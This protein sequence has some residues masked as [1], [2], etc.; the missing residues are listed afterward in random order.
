L[1]IPPLKKIPSAG[2]NKIKIIDVESI[3]YVHSDET[4]VFVV[5]NEK[6]YFTE[7][8]LKVLENRTKL[9]RC[10]KQFLINPDKIDEILFDNN[11]TGKI[12]TISQHLI[13]IS[14]HYLKELK[15]KLGL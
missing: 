13:P 8:T 4:G 10:H 7:I 1:E 11:S 15:E 2:N 6:K 9:F 3:E 5:S 14:R 12:K